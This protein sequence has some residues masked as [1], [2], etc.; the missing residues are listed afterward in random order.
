MAE[1]RNCKKSEKITAGICIGVLFA[2]FALVLT[3][4]FVREI[5]I[6]RLRIENSFTDFL[7]IGNE[8]LNEGG[9]ESGG[10]GSAQDIDWEALYPF[11]Q[12]E[13]GESIERKTTAVNQ[14]LDG[15]SYIERVI[16]SYCTSYLFRRY[17][18]VGLLRTIEQWI[19]WKFVSYAEYNGV[20][21]L[22]DGYLTTYTPRKS[23][24]GQAESLILFRDFCESENIEF[25]YV[26][27]PFKVDKY[28]DTQIS[29]VIDFSNQ[30]A[31]D[32]LVL[33][34]DNQVNFLDLREVAHEEGLMRKDLFYR[35]DHHWLTTAGLWGAQR[36]LEYCNG[37]YDF[38][39]ETSLLN[40]DQFEQ[41]LYPEW[42]LGS[43]GKKVTLARTEPEDFVLLYPKYD[44]NFHYIVPDKE[45]DVVG[46]YS[47]FYD[48]EQI[49]EKDYYGK[50]PYLTNKYGTRPVDKI[51]NMGSADE[52]RI[53]V[54]GD[55]YELCYVPCLAICEKEVDALDLRYFTGSVRTFAKMMNPDIVIILYNADSLGG[56]IDWN[57]HTDLFDFR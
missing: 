48:M 35:T 56:T 9:G 37:H 49:S 29:G 50:D 6:K 8:R 23:I 16:Q 10:G 51:W 21:F 40:L 26:Q 46:D 15:V 20:A 42:Y 39:A 30:N 22:P 27:A 34:K 12:E 47:A 7:F 52:K 11:S 25:L 3:I 14:Y 38:Q 44:T 5:G 13:I 24:V 18:L 2:C 31:D 4:F 19:N 1:K 41:V 43:Q 45:I 17:E 28:E 54:I 53:L 57:S 33:L 55:S 36:T 32:F